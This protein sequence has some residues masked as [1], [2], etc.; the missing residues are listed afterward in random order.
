M[1]FQGRRPNE[2]GV[3]R[4]DSSSAAQVAS[5]NLRVSKA[6]VRVRHQGS[7]EPAGSGGVMD[8]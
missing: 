7:K 8:T 5:G 2:D 1:N 4:R 3:R 6:L